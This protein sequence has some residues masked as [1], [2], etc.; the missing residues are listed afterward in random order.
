[1]QI[2]RTEVTP[3][4]TPS[5]HSV[6]R[7]KF[8]GEGGDCVTVD[9][10]AVA[11][12]EDGAAVERAKAILVQT[13]TFDSAV[14]EYDALSNG[15]FDEVAVVSANSEHGGVYFFEYRDGQGGRLPPVR[16][17]SPNAAREEALRIAVDLFVDL[18]PGQDELTGWLVRAYAENGDL[19]CA[20]DVQEAEAAHQTR[21]G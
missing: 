7:V 10:A 17:P 11:N 4:I 13:A 18:H 6:L 14:N 19:L 9:M 20:I 16:M 1:M 3:A 15:N 21:Q 8:C 2:I 12:G 5:G